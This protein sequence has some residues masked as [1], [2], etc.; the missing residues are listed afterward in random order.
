[1]RKQVA[2]IS[3]ALTA[4]H[5][6]GA[7]GAVAQP[8]L[9]LHPF[10]KCFYI[11]TAFEGSA[12]TLEHPVGVN[13]AGLAVLLCLL[14]EGIQQPHL[15]IFDCWLVG[16]QGGI[17]YP[18]LVVIPDLSSNSVCFGVGNRV[19]PP[20]DAVDEV[21]L[22]IQTQPDLHHAVVITQDRWFLHWRVRSGGDWVRL[23]QAFWRQDH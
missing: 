1:M 10:D 23:L 21:V 22:P 15:L 18:L 12:V 13:A 5:Q 2:V 6:D 11:T 14:F 20:T 16:E 8:T 19:I 4:V 7:D 9:L 3:R 17:Q